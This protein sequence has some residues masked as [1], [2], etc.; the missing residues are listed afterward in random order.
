[1]LLRS[2]WPP[3]LQGIKHA[4]RKLDGCALDWLAEMAM[5]QE[6]WRCCDFAE[7]LSAR[8]GKS[9]TARDVSRGSAEL[10][11]SLLRVTKAA[12]ER[13][14]HARAVIRA[15]M[16]A[17]YKADMLVFL[18]EVSTVSADDSCCNVNAWQQRDV[19]ETPAH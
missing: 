3:C 5:Q 4:S 6:L 17:T 16:T 7:Q 2:S 15:R 8:T 18:D 1:M 12:A 9:I 19:V 13:D 14:E 10:G 11:F